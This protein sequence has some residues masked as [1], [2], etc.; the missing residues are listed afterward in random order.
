MSLTTVTYD[1]YSLTR[2][3]LVKRS[4]IGGELSKGNAKTKDVVGHLPFQKTKN[5]EK[6]RKYIQKVQ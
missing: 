3:R 4:K 1:W 2:T 6:R 5:E